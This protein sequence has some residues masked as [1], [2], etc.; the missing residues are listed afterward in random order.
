MTFPEDVTV[1]RVKIIGNR[2]IAYPGYLPARSPELT[3][4]IESGAA[5]PA[6]PVTVAPIPGDAEY[7]FARPVEGVRA[8][9]IQ[10]KVT[11]PGVGIAEVVVE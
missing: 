2:E 6:K 5:L 4:K 7:T 9:R 8:V 3:L 1:T 10:G 11:A